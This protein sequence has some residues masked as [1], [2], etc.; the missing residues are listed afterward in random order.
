[1]TNQQQPKPPP[2]ED[3]EGDVQPEGKQLTLT[4]DDD[5]R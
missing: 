3:R 1:M 2:W 5:R 4:M